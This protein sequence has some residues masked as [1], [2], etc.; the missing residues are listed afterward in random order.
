MAEFSVRFEMP[1]N[2]WMG[3]ELNRQNEQ[4][5]MAASYLLYP[6]APYQLIRCLSSVLGNKQDAGMIWYLEPDEYHF[7][8]T[9][10]NNLTRFEVNEPYASDTK[11][12]THFA[13]EVPSFEMVL[14]FWRGLRCLQSQ[15][16]DDEFQVGWKSPFPDKELDELTEQ[17]REIN[18]KE[19]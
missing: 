12:K 14:V 7:E 2:G 6:H 8:F 13:I 16:L 1:R 4:F 17:I 15:I 18:R 5:K 11:V 9:R 3:I 19:K 10:E